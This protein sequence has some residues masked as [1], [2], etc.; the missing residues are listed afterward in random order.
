MVEEFEV[1]ESEGVVGSSRES[2]SESEDL[3]R[4]IRGGGESGDLVREVRG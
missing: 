3:V 4:G 1:S 2:D